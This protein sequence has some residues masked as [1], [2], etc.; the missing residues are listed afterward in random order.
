MFRGAIHEWTDFDHLLHGVNPDLKFSVEYDH[1]R[2]S[3][4]DMRAELC[5][6]SLIITLYQKKDLQKYFPFGLQCLSHS[7]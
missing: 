3:F 4:L 5:I 2:A 6:G 1:K 7:F